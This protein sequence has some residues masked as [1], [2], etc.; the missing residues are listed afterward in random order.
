MQ[1]LLSLILIGWRRIPA[2][3]KLRHN[4]EIPRMAG[5]PTSQDSSARYSNLIITITRMITIKNP[6]MMTSLVLGR[7][8]ETPQV[9]IRFPSRH[10]V[11][12]LYFSTPRLRALSHRESISSFFRNQFD[13]GIY[14]P[15]KNT[16]CLDPSY[17]TESARHG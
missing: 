5:N 3:G 14:C 16:S 8:D 17:R 15:L 4:P 9:K 10:Q 12:S 7:S 2:N 13:P 11:Y 6:I 1:K